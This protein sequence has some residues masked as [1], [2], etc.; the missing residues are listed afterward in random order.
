MARCD[1]GRLLAT[2][3]A[4]VGDSAVDLLAD[5]HAPVLLVAGERD[6][7]TPRAMVEEMERSLPG[8]RL[9]VYERA[10]HYL[11]IEYP[12]RL[13]DDIRKFLSDF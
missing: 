7:F 6:Q 4:V 5:I 8:A 12:G 3:E 2:F 13:S 11:P 9:E 1:L 10:T